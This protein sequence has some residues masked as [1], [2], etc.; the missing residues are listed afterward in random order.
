MKAAPA[1]PRV[2]VTNLEKCTA[3]T[4]E[5][6]K[7]LHML[8]DPQTAAKALLIWVKVLNTTLKDL[9]CK[10]LEEKRAD[11]DLK[12][13]QKDD[14]STE[15]AEADEDDSDCEE[16][17][18]KKY[19]SEN[20]ESSHFDWTTVCHM[21]DIF[22]LDAEVMK[23]VSELAMVCFE[24]GCHGNVST[25]VNPEEPSER[26]RSATDPVMDDDLELAYFVR[27]YFCFMSVSR[28]K[29]MIERRNE[30]SIQTW[31]A[32]TVCLKGK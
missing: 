3:L 13:A 23:H 19:L 25:Y 21:T 22:H 26:E 30:A 24:S 15:N 14:N 28:I 1:Y 27:C 7:N 9:H 29:D 16:H 5:R 32:F 17:G 18:A 11:E 6:L 2:N 20:Q 8:L 4:K 10:M 12:R 31:F